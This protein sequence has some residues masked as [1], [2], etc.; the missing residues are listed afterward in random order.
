M[1]WNNKHKERTR[2]RIVNSA[3]KLFTQFG[4]DNIGINEIML[5]AGLTRGA[6]YAHFATKSELYSEAIIAGALLR[7][8]QHNVK[9]ASLQDLVSHYLSKEHFAGTGQQCPL[10]FLTTDI[11][12][13]DKQVSHAYTRVFKGLIKHLENRE[14]S[15]SQAINQAVL[16]IGGVAISGALDDAELVEELLLSCQQNEARN[17]L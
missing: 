12:Q 14:L 5:D 2:Q 11:S 9:E 7:M 16:M 3:A 10:A 4:F 6:F 15:R 1:A 17:T 13:R 8:E